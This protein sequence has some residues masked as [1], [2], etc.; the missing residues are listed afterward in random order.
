MTLPAPMAQSDPNLLQTIH[1][2]SE[3][4]NGS[5]RGRIFYL[6]ETLDTDNNVACVEEM[7]LSKMRGCDLGHLFLAELMVH[8][9]RFDILRKVLNANRS[10]MERIMRSRQVLPRF[11]VLMVNIS[12][13]IASEDLNSVKFLLRSTLPHEKIDKAKNFL[14]LI[15]ELEKLD[16]VSSEKVD[17]VEECLRN[18]GRVDL[19][20]KVNVYK[21]SGVAPEAHSSQWQ[22]HRV[23]SPSPTPNSSYSIQQRRFGRSRHNENTPASS[24]RLPSCQICWNIHL[25]LSTSMWS[26]TNGWVWMTLF[27]LSGGC[28]VG[29][30]TMKVMASSVASL[31]VARLVNSWPLTHTVQV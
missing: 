15:T 5:E 2:I 9:R 17:F 21:M 7:L 6:C 4:L 16:R 8:L 19:A 24:Y 28:L 20:K 1:R 26:S 18:V 22:S 13:D 25:S 11:R 23:P 12:E 14:D 30:K 29:E 31:A 3:A 10:E 27:Q